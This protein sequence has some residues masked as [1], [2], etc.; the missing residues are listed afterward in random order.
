MFSWPLRMR[1]MTFERHGV[2]KN[3][4][5]SISSHVTVNDEPDEQCISE[6][7]GRE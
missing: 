7:S 3:L 5:A 2:D 6:I 1:T 4:G